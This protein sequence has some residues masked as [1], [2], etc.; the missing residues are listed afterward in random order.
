MG[1]ERLDGVALRRGQVV[2]AVEEDRRGAPARGLHAQRVERGLVVQDAIAAAQLLQTVAIGAVESR[3]LLGI[4]GAPR[5][6]LSPRAHGDPPARGIDAPLLEL[7]AES[8]QRL[9]EARRGGRRAERF[10]L[11]AGDGGRRHA[12][13]R[14]APERLPPDARALGDLAHEPGEGHHAHAEDRTG[15]RELAPVVVD[16]GEGR[17]DEQ[18][19]VVQCRPVSGEHMACLLGVGWTGDEGERHGTA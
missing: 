4:G 17:H 10:Q 1:G 7:A 15:V 9:D 13:A 18:R 11:R 8:Q 2:E 3:E 6:A 5:L 14:Q 16:V 19:L 12:L